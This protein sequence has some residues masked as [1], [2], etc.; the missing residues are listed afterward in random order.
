MYSGRNLNLFTD[1]YS[2]G[3]DYYADLGFTPRLINYDAVKDTS[4]RLGHEQ[5]HSEA[6]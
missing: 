1:L 4:I 6:A 2:V 5:W 3:T